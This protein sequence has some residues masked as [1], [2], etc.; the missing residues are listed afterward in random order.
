ML[1]TGMNTQE[2]MATLLEQQRRLKVGKRAVQMFPV[3]TNELPLPEG[4]SRCVNTR[5]I[6]HY[7]SDAI[8]EAKIKELSADGRE[9]EFLEL[10]P[11]SK[12]EIMTRIAAGDKPVVIVEYTKDFVEVRAWLGCI[13]TVGEQSDYFYRTKDPGNIVICRVPERVEKALGA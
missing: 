7:L 2:S 12:P 4:F 3:N 1:D 9:N 11:Y 10:G 13:S 8:T 6:F 5:G